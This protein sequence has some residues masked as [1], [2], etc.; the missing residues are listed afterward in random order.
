M[1]C[2]DLPKDS[3]ARLVPKSAFSTASSAPTASALNV[4]R[5]SSSTATP[6]VSKVVV[7]TSGKT[8]ESQMPLKKSTTGPVFVPLATKVPTRVMT[9]LVPNSPTVLTVRLRTDGSL[10]ATTVVLLVVLSAQH[11]LVLPTKVTV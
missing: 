10:T 2:Q 6:S 11:V 5:T 8:A 7:L 4:T 3:S 1:P 9:V